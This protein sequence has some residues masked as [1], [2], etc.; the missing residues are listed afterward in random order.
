MTLSRR[1]FLASAGLLGVAAATAGSGLLSPASA[2]RPRTQP[3]IDPLHCPI[4]T[5]VVVMMENRS[6][7]HY[8][9]TLP[10]VEG[11]RAGMSNP[12]AD[13]RPVPIF[14]LGDDVIA[15]PD[16]DHSWTGGRRQLDGGRMDGFVV[17]TG[18]AEPMG[19]YT[20]R[21]IPWMR[22]FASTYT[23][24]DHWF[25]SHLG[26]TYPNRN[27]LHA[28]QDF[29]LKSNDSD[30][31]TDPRTI[32][33]LLDAAGVS[34]KYYFIDLPFLATYPKFQQ[35]VE[36]GHIGTAADYLRDAIAGRLPP[37][38]IVDPGFYVNDDPPP[39]DI[40][41][42]QSYLSDI[43]DALAA[44]PHWA[45]SA[46]FVT[47]DEWGGF[48]DH[49]VPPKFPDLRPSTDLMDDHSQAGFRVPTMVAGPW[50]RRGH[51]VSDAMEHAS[52]T[53]FI[54]WRFG[55]ESLTPRDAAALNPAA[56]AFDFAR[57]DFTKPVLPMPK[58]DPV[59]A[60][61]SAASL[62]TA[63]NPVP[64][65][66]A[67]AL[68]NAPRELLQLPETGIRVPTFSRTTGLVTD[69]LRVQVPAP[70]RG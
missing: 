55:L 18:S 29:G 23:T 3:L 32:Y 30:Y 50:A 47:Y 6:F 31:G 58:I 42:G 69:L 51:I 37:V 43:H 28:A 33:D 59:A 10:G 44:G 46:L 53:R 63:A 24:F 22:A 40:Q 11:L 35:W 65:L 7:D 19:Y 62:L 60:A 34:W 66:T 67:D 61:T 26:S 52:I 48:F 1:D 25:C 36:A 56:V 21:T 13:G 5:I 41:L 15:D 9:G 12:D 38:S 4:D 27:Y 17:T 20:A 64:E 54:E 57:P 14:E 45:S 49:V 2:R 16:P 68:A 39:A 8:L 70:A